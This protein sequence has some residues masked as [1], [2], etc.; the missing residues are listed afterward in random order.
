MRKFLTATFI[1]LAFFISATGAAPAVSAQTATNADNTADYAAGDPENTADYEVNA[2]PTTPAATSVTNQPNTAAQNTPNTPA[3]GNDLNSTYSNVMITIMKLFAWL[4]GVAAITLNYAA[5]FTVVTMGNYIH[6][7]SA[8][9]VVW[10][11]LRDF[12]NIM[13]IFGFLGA[14]IATIFNVEKYGFGTKMLPMLLVAAVALNFSLFISEAMVDAT[15]LF[16]T[17]FYTQIN[18]GSLPTIAP[19]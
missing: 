4:V 15:N 1:I 13:L 16:A 2:V 6:N 14:G 8:V 17:E 7:L 3:L 5:Y 18:G 12:A 11:I 9:G 10:R 19:E